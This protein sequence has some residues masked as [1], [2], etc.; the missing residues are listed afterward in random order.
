M[1]RVTRRRCG[2]PGGGAETLARAQR[3]AADPESVQALRAIFAQAADPDDPESSAAAE[4]LRT[5]ETPR[6]VLVWVAGGPGVH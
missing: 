2:A 3:L 4:W 6:D 5:R 1:G